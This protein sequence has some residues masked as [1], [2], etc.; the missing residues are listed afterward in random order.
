MIGGKL[1]GRLSRR[2]IWNSV[3]CIVGGCRRVPT[4]RLWPGVDLGGCCGFQ[5]SRMLMI[6]FY[7]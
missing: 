2:V 6:R 3:V 1:V 5:V 7:R 4:R